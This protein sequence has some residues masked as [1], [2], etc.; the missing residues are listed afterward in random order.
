MRFVPP[1]LRPSVK[2]RANSRRSRREHL[3]GERRTL[4]EHVIRVE[5]LLDEGAI[6]HVPNTCFGEF[7]CDPPPRLVLQLVVPSDVGG[8]EACGVIDRVVG[9]LFPCAKHAPIIADHLLGVV[10]ALST[11]KAVHVRV[12]PRLVAVAKQSED[13]LA[14]LPGLRRLRANRVKRLERLVALADP[15][16]VPVRRDLLP[17]VDAGNRARLTQDRELLLA[18]QVVADVTVVDAAALVPGVRVADE[19]G[20]RH[21]SA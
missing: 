8:V 2:N 20:G 4:R 21:G 14:Q 12:P 5:I 6:G 18:L 19:D 9:T 10:G 3:S 16:V 7:S 1:F 11:R 17:V 13:R 15:I